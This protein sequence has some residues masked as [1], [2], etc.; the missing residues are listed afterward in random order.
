MNLD[1][2]LG[3]QVWSKIVK[4]SLPRE[5]DDVYGKFGGMEG[6]L[7]E[8]GGL[9]EIF[10]NDRERAFT[11]RCKMGHSRQLIRRYVLRV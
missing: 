7:L 10:S 8:R 6:Y 11:S 1:F 5:I 3:L 4:F 9:V 2:K